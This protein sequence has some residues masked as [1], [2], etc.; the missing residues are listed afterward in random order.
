MVADIDGVRCKVLSE[1]ADHCCTE[2]TINLPIPQSEVIERSAWVYAEADWDQLR[3]RM[4][5][6]DWDILRGM[7]ADATAEFMTNAILEA[8]RA[9]IPVKK[10]RERKSTHPWV[11]ERVMKLVRRKNAAAGTAV[12]KE[13][14]Q[15]CSA[16]LKEEFSKYVTS[17]RGRLQKVPRASK[18][19]WAMARRLLQQKS[20][21]SNIP[22]LKKIDSGWCMESKTKADLLAESFKS[23]GALPDKIMNCYSEIDLPSYRR[24]PELK[25]P[26]E[27]QAVL[28]L[29]G[30][31]SDSGTGPDEIPVNILKNCATEL[32]K[33][34]CILAT[35]ILEEG[36][37]PDVWTR[38]W[39]VPLFKKGS[40]SSAGNYRG[41]HL[42]AQL[43]K[44]LERLLRSLFLPF[45]VMH[46]GFGPNQFAYMEGRRACTSATEV[47]QDYG[48][49]QEDS[50]LLLRRGWR[51]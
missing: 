3:A 5:S 41:V 9:C 12:F 21:T 50:S 7:S 16:G 38:H 4:A 33:P 37:W 28:F 40:T 13:A 43:S 44:V 23:K 1:I 32:A 11:N 49:T 17:E 10:V 31:R 14:M 46:N 35:I 30:L 25:Q 42:T 19:W 48:E 36:R 6:I 8:A 15:E 51:F 24:Q 29:K 26:D 22:A 2:S 45:L 27:D 18:G 47:D 34:V 39:I 20:K